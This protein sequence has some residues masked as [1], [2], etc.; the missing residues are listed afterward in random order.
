MERSDDGRSIK[1]ILKRIL[2][3]EGVIRIKT[4]R[5][6]ICNCKS[7]IILQNRANIVVRR[8]TL[9]TALL[10]RKRT[11]GKIFTTGVHVKTQN[12]KRRPKHSEAEPFEFNIT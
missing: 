2:I 7:D 11:L 5:R 3:A 6:L 12:K 10:R 1:G 4:N 9:N 8:T